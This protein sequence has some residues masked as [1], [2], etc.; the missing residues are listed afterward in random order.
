MKLFQYWE[1]YIYIFTINNGGG[2]IELR[3]SDS[4]T[5]GG[6]IDVQFAGSSSDYTSRIIEDGSGQV[7]Y[8]GSAR[9]TATASTSSAVIAT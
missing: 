3:P 7:C 1:K 2:T 9:G 8:L 4:T 6:I 5:D